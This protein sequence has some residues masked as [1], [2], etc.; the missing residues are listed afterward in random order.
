MPFYI[1]APD[2][3]T[4]VAQGVSRWSKARGYQKLKTH[5]FQGQ[6]FPSLEVIQECLLAARLL[7]TSVSSLADPHHRV[8]GVFGRENLR[9]SADFY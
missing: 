8:L 3:S 4:F 5:Y 2:R 9:V 6:S 1:E 7:P